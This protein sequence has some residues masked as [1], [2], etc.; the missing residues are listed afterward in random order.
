MQKEQRIAISLMTPPKLIHHAKLDCDTR[1]AW[2]LPR[3][4]ISV[5][6]YKSV[7]CLKC[8]TYI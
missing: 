1:G 8:Y 5:K 7:L 4:H 6:Q 3:Y 2:A